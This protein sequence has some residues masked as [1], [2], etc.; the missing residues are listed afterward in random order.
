MMRDDK[1]LKLCVAFFIVAVCDMR[2][3]EGDDADMAVWSSGGVPQV[4][5]AHHPDSR[6]PAVVAAAVRRVPGPGVAAQEIV[7]RGGRGGVGWRS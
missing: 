2:Q 1:I 7:G 5:G 4:S 3:L 6:V